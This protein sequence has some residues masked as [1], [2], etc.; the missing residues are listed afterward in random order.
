MKAWTYQDGH[1]V[2][3]VGADN[4]SWY[5][6]WYTPSGKRR[7]ETC[8]PG[9]L[10]RKL[11]VKLRRKREAELIEGTYED[12]SRA[13]W[14]EFRQEYD[15]KVLAGLDGRNREATSHALRQ[16]E[17]IIKPARM[18]GINSLT[19]AE[20]VAKR[21][22]EGGLRPDS[23]ISPATVNKDLRHLR[24]VLR[25]AWKWEY[26]SEAPEFAFLKEAKKLPTYVPPEHFAA[27]YL[28]CD[29]AKLP[30]DQPYPAAD[31]W[32]GLLIL[33]YM[34]GWRI[35]AILALCRE[36]VDLDA[37]RALSRAKD[38]KGKRDQYVVLHPLVVEHLRKLT[39]FGAKVFPWNYR[40]A[41]IFSKLA[42]IQAAAGVKS[43]GK[44][45]Y[46][47]HDLRRG[48]AT[49]NAD[50]LS[51]DALQALMQHQDYKTTQRYINMAR[52]L[53]P[54]LEKLYVPDL[55]QV[56]ASLPKLAVSQTA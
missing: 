1:Q 37:G 3:K 46:T 26:L 20:F 56:V 55:P 54:A 30:A 39:A 50:R 25:R 36:D 52:Q 53:N 33:A 27:I 2:K 17:R 51:A 35:G 23:I 43:V 5:V 6:G 41:T 38:N 13:T 8:G 49:L 21:R 40:R 45:H 28:A 11:A 12:K 42:E 4:A 22:A 15:A 29:Q 32:R 48:F 16:F 44:D 19:V 14:E 9:V 24:A 47:F 18:R 10:G 34:T 31:W 7:C